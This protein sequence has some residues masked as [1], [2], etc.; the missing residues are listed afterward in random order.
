MTQDD[1]IYFKS[2]FADYTRSYYSNDKEDQ[3]NILLK[4]EHTDNVCGNIARIARGSSL[5]DNQTMLAEAVAL[6]HDVGRFSQYTKYKTFRDAISINHGLLG[7]KIL[8]E[9]KVL[10][11]L[12]GDEQQ[13]IIQAVKYHNAF[14]IPTLPDNKTI[15]FLKLIRDA[16]KLDIFRVFIKYYESPVEERASATAFSMP[17]TPEYSHIML[18]CIMNNHVAS[19]ATIRNENDF[20]LMKLSWIYDLHYKE[21]VRLLVENNYM[22][23]II[24]KLPCTEDIR[25]AI[26]VLREYVRQRLSNGE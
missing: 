18:A 6:F 1:L 14:A 26:I 13:L 8:I 4:V 16:D 11:R 21:S 25:A 9:E 2:W 22:N 17:D 5:D 15:S 20:K 3:K 24:D 19:Y 7:S 12:P 10:Q 23:R